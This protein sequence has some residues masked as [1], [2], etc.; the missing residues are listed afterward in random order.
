MRLSLVDVKRNNDTTAAHS[1]AGD[2]LREV[3]A[4]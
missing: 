3:P 4:L 2:A 1:G